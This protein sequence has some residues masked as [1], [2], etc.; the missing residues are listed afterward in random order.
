MSK[1]TNEERVWLTA[2]ESTVRSWCRGQF[3][4]VRAVTGRSSVLVSV[5]LRRTKD[6]A[7]ARLDFSC[8]WGCGF[9][10][11]DWLA[12]QLAKRLGGLVA[13]G[14]KI[15]LDGLRTKVRTP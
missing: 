7:I 10:S 12:H 1:E 15:G 2:V 9:Y 8:P 5:Y 14:A 4:T 11:R 6:V 3:T 13:P